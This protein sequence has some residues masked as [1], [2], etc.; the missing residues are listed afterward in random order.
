MTIKIHVR[1]MTFKHAKHTAH[2]I[3]QKNKQN[4]ECPK[5]Y[6]LITTQ[7][8]KQA[9]TTQLITKWQQHCNIIQCWSMVMHS[10]SFTL[11]NIMSTLGNWL[12]H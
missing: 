7:Q 10:T 9:Y 4:Y 12:R 3:L 5:I 11:Q 8:W 1:G 2:K 6:Q